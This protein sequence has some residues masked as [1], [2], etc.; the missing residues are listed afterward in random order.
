MRRLQIARLS[1]VTSAAFVI[2]VSLLLAPIALAINDYPWPSSDPNLLSPLGF[3]YR[4]CTD[5][6]A[7]RL[8]KQQG[9]TASPWAFT[10]STLGFPAGKG[11]A[12][13]WKSYAAAAGYTVNK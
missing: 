5:F 3:D 4:N 13:D 11:N 9:V 10:W 8:N 6:V 1:A 2:A 7:W 12:V